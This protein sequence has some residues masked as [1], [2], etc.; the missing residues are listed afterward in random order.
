M[1]FVHPD[2]LASTSYLTDDQ[3]K[4]FEHVQY[5]PFGETRVQESKGRA[6]EYLFTSKELDQDTGLYYFGTRYYDPRTSVWI[7]AD[8]A[9]DKFL[10]TGDKDRDS[11]L[12]GS[13]GLFNTDAR[14]RRWQCR[15]QGL[16]FSA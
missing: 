5:F 6:S 16:D 15:S 8:P 3:G 13:G 10:P 11:N 1:L 12:P 9:L 4:V 14:N 7:S 2:H